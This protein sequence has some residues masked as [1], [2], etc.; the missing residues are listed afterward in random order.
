MS[1]N[2]LES[3]ELVEDHGEA[4]DQFNGSA[5]AP[6]K[7]YS[8]AEENYIKS[9]YYIMPILLY[10]YRKGANGEVDEPECII[11]HHDD[12]MTFDLIFQL[13]Q[14]EMISKKQEF[15]LRS[16]MENIETGACSEKEDAD[17]L[18]KPMV[19]DM[20]LGLPPTVKET[21]EA[22]NE[23]IELTFTITPLILFIKKLQ[24][25]KASL[26]INN[27]DDYDL[28]P[29]KASD[30][31]H[32]QALTRIMNAIGRSEGAIKMSSMNYMP[33]MHF[34]SEE[35][36]ILKGIQTAVKSQVCGEVLPVSFNRILAML[37]PEAVQKNFPLGSN[38]LH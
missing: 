34:Q 36:A 8:Q 26:K 2:S 10:L 17:T 16:L 14:D 30:E 1:R 9:I 18:Q 33:S 24:E 12:N 38:H 35:E 27:L 37:E 22:K 5:S 11:G 21:I 20:S 13:S 23:T 3:R 15:L 31:S 29:I 19:I 25:Y 6:A 32:S 28:A 7:K 4:V